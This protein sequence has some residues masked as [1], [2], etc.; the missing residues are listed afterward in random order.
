MI[1]TIITTRTTTATTTIIITNNNDSQKLPKRKYKIK[2][3]NPL[4]FIRKPFLCLSLG[5]FNIMLEIRLRFIFLFS[6]LIYL[7]RFN[8]NKKRHFLTYMLPHV[9]NFTTYICFMVVLVL[10]SSFDS[11]F[12]SF[13]LYEF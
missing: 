9:S 1:V 13:N 5:F 11:T 10:F 12:S 2:Q 7:V 6:L 4:F 3:N 8:T